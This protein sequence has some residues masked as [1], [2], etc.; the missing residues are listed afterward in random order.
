MTRQ[1]A[2]R[3]HFP[4]HIQR[5][6]EASPG[7]PS[8]GDVDLVK[9]YFIHIPGPQN[10]FI[11]ILVSLVPRSLEIGVG[12]TRHASFG[13]SVPSSGPIWGL[14]FFRGAP[15]LG[16]VGL[17]WWLTLSLQAM[18]TPCNFYR[19]FITCLVDKRDILRCQN[20]APKGYTKT[21]RA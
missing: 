16:H 6:G 11:H 15:I 7:P 21:S 2:R 20:A 18:R 12:L 9:I 5:P 4:I 17:D 8:P 13:M 3:C 14:S 10:H 1:V 19:L